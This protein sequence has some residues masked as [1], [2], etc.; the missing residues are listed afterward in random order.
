M[1]SYYQSALATRGDYPVQ[2]RGLNTGL[3]G[4]LSWRWQNWEPYARYERYDF[5]DES[6]LANSYRRHSPIVGLRAYH[7][8][9]SWY[10]E[11]KDEQYRPPQAGL[12]STG[13]L[14]RL[15]G[16]YYLSEKFS[17]FG[18]LN[19]R[20]DGSLLGG[21][22]GFSWQLPYDIQLRFYGRHEQGARGVADFADTFA[23]NQINVQ[24][25]KK[26]RWGQKIPIAGA[27]PGQEWLGSG[28]IEGYV[29]EDLNLNHLKDP[30]EPGLPAVTLSL[31]DGT[32]TETDE[33]GY[34]RFP[35]VSAGTTTVRLDARRIPASYTYLD[36]QLAT[37]TIQRRAKAKVDFPFIRGVQIKGRV[38]AVNSKGQA[39]QGLPDVLVLVQP[40]DHNTFTDSEG[41]FAFS[42]L[43]PGT[44][45]VSLHPESL[46]EHAQIQ[47]PAVQSVTLAPGERRENLLF[48]VQTERPVLIL[49]HLGA[50]QD[51]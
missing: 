29:F 51:H 37:L 19:Y 2:L 33:R 38:V 4:E 15:G 22:A 14:L 31:P 17:F 41:Y 30:G 18:E 21:Y 35:A 48:R 26:C 40:G 36:D 46:P 23:A 1:L 8:K 45:E 42:G 50:G 43:P 47:A 16:S 3:Y 11:G 28:S 12:G 25:S 5:H 32:T 20:P 27:Q 44:Y 49:S 34:Y 13:L 9:I 10:V 7:G 39:G 6:G 24:I